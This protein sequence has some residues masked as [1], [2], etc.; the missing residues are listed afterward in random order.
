MK[1]AVIFDIDG[2]AINSPAQK[3]PTNRLIKATHALKN[4]YYVCAASGRSKSF[5]RTV[6]SDLGLTDL[7]IIG[8][9][10]QIV[11]PLTMEVVWQ[12]TISESAVHDYVEIA[13]KFTYGLLWN[14]S[15]EEEYLS[16]G[17]KL[18]TFIESES[19]YFLQFCF[20]PDD[21]VEALVTEI[22]AVDGLLPATVPAQR[23][24]T[25]DVHITNP[26]A[27][28][29]YAITELITRLGIDH[30]D[31]IGIGDGRND[32]HLFAGVHTKIAMGSVVDELKAAAHRIIDTV[33]NDGLA[34]YFEELAVK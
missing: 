24:H 30:A 14:D 8:A 33:Q 29:E 13:K 28:K 15:T 2:K 27:T 25:K 16:G 21:E 12:V 22:N 26:V 5:A 19:I 3:S 23:P 6:L 11:D 31:T 10:T 4:D 18:D 17:R 1:K 9:G 7:C 34:H 20:V 32:L